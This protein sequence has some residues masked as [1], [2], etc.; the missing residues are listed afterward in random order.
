MS[1]RHASKSSTSMS[2][3]KRPKLKNSRSSSPASN[4]ASE[5]EVLMA[6]NGLL[7]NS[8]DI[9]RR[10]LGVDDRIPSSWIMENANGLRLP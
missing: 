9:Q 4:G 1:T 6:Q 7:G 8:L 5:R 10:A 3:E 2:P